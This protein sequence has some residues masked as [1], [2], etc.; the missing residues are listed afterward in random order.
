MKLRNIISV[1]ILAVYSIV[2]A[3]NIIPHH[4]HSDFARATYHSCEY[5]DHHNHQ[6]EIGN[7]CS[8]HN[9]HDKHSHNHCSFEE[10]TLLTKSISLSDLFIPSTEIELAGVEKNR[11][12]VLDCY[13]PTQ[14]SAL[15]CRDV[16][17]RGPP[18][19]S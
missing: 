13:M 18:Q 12:T 15:H 14:I 7:T 4:H 16:L 1:V 2:I 3:H 10:I 5:S 8:V 6:A 9:N 11:Q 19:F 17:L